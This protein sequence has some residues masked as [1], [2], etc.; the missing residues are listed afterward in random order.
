MASTSTNVTHEML[1]A[2][3]HDTVSMHAIMPCLDSLDFATDWHDESRG[4]QQYCAEHKSD[5]CG[6]HD[7]AD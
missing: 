2:Q 6:L 5:G 3:P 4:A 7:L 1:I